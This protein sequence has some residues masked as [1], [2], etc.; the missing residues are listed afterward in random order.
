M[1]GAERVVLC[2]EDEVFV[3]MFVADALNDAGFLVLEAGSAAEALSI[4]QDRD[5]VQALV[6]DVDMPPGMNGFALARNVSERWA[7]I[8]IIVLSGRFSP[9]P[10][11]LPAGS[12]FLGK[13]VSEAKLVGEVIRAVGGTDPSK[14]N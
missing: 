2:V 3:R 14:M 10:G 1:P 9:S 13:P 7:N 6:T 4:L 8:P 11:D 5:D 12:V